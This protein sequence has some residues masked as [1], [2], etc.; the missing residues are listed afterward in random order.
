MSILRKNYT[1]SNGTTFSS[2][3]EELANFEFFQSGSDSYRIILAKC[4]GSMKVG[5]SKFWLEPNSQKFL[6]TKKSHV[7]MPLEAWTMFMT[8]GVKFVNS[9]I[10]AEANGMQ[11]VIS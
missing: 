6:P 4:N 7:F 1:T 11:M 10:R 3:F 2:V 9:A 8:N 5:M